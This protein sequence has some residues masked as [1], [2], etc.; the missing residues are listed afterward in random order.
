MSRKFKN[1]SLRKICERGL[2][3]LVLSTLSHAALAI[4]A[5]PHAIVAEQPDG[6]QVELYLRGTPG[7]SWL[8][9]S[10]GYPVAKK[11]NSYVYQTT[12]NPNARST[13]LLVGEVNPQDEGIKKLSA[14][15]RGV[16]RQW[17]FNPRPQ[18]APS[19]FTPG[20]SQKVTSG[21]VN[22]LVLRIRFANHA[23]RSLPS[24]AQF[25]SLMNNTSTDPVNAPTGS[26]RDYYLKN[27]Y[28]GL[29]LNSTVTDWI[30][31]SNTEQYYANGQ[32]GGTQLWQAIKEALAV[33]D[34]TLDFSNFD[35]DNDGYIDSI[36]IIHSGYGAEWGG[37]DSD[38]VYYTDRIWSHK[39][40]LYSGAYVSGE[41]VSVFDYNINPGLW[42][43]SGSAIG[44]MGVIAHELG[45]FLG[46]PDLYD[47]DNS[48]E[49][50]GS[51]GLM[52]NSWGFTGT[53]LNPPNLSAWSKTE[54]AWIVPTNIS[55][56][57]VYSVAASDATAQA[58]RID[59]NA[60]SEYLLI[61]NRQPLNFESTM[62]QGGLAI[63]HIDENVANNRDEGYPG[64]SGWPGDHYKVAIAQADGNF[65]LENGNNRGDSG[66]LYHSAAQDH[67]DDSTSP[68][69]QGY[70][71]GV[72][73]N[74][75]IDINSISAASNSMQFTL[76]S[77]SGSYV[78]NGLTATVVLS[79]GQSPTAGSDVILGTS[80]ADT[81]NA[82]AGDDTICALGGADTINAG[83]GNDLV[84]ADG[85]D[86]VVFGGSGDDTLYGDS[87]SDFLSGQSG[88]DIVDG[89][90]GVDNLRG[91]PGSD[92]I[93][94]GNGATVGTGSFAS[95]GGAADTIF[96]G[97]HA[98]DIRG[99]GGA[100]II[101]GYDGDDT[102]TGGNGQDVISGGQ[103]NDTIKGQVSRDTL[104]GDGGDD[105]ITGGSGNDSLSGG[106][107]DDTLTGNADDDSC[108]GNAGTDTAT[109]C[110]TINNVP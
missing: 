110:E 71:T 19:S 74:Y 16:Y 79:L 25:E 12:A 3:L 21:Q 17:M 93:Y 30:T 24:K 55:A 32:S 56:N 22:N 41:G 77:A 84:F 20:A 90:A 4:T 96:G 51:W 67:I 101:Y 68:S 92:T 50:I 59:L 61:E 42:S 47:T 100:D 99:A 39:W 66:D 37:Y 83:P 69:T 107:G 102:I 53:Q 31:V 40:A 35:I 108:D 109:S 48:S 95:G 76:G 85:G 27:S 44:R 26:V 1:V 106:D 72:L 97:P 8:E 103:G 89:G 43:T 86:D 15:S 33:V 98:D 7:L 13:G 34:T 58:Y 2:A 60:P 29:T 5:S 18:F 70:S 36:T 65:D 9:D 91:G 87:G 64:S 10:L 62:P 57:G 88:E 38:S 6:S 45:H 104:Y 54:L 52:A 49:G 75:G 73:V 28:G 14:S 105:V 81:I 80:G 78:C 82:L 23:T 46:L 11:N 94:T 63:W